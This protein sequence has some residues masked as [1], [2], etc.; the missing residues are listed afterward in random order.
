MKD[1][2]A[3]KAQQ[4]ADKLACEA[5]NVRLAQLGGPLQPSPSLRAAIHGGF[6]WLRVECNGCQQR[7]WLDLRQVRR[8]PETPIWQLQGALVCEPCRRGRTYG[9]RATIEMLCNY[10]KQTGPSPYQERD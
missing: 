5:W 1:E 4:L 8:R 9:P 6:P 2:E 10:D 3:R 7:A